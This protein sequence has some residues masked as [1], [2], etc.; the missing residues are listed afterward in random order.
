M[1]KEIHRILRDSSV[2][3]VLDNLRRSFDVISSKEGDCLEVELSNIKLEI[4]FEK[5][6]VKKYNN[7]TEDVSFEFGNLEERISEYIDDLFKR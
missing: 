7:L 3:T 5:G 6:M 4:F 1:Q 2:Y